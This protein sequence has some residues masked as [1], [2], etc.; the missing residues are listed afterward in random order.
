M[1]V[2]FLDIDG[3]LAWGTWFDGKVKIETDFTIPYPWVQGECDSLSRIIKATDAKIVLSSDWR[4][5]YSIEQMRDIFTH[6][7]IPN[8][9]IDYTSRYKVK[10]SSSGRMDRAKQILNWVKENKPEAW[11]AIDDYNL[12]YEFFMEGYNDNYIATRGDHSEGIS[13][14]ISSQEYDI[15]NILNKKEDDAIF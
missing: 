9:I 12:E 13:S 10:M 5:Y 14:T 8:V 3:P 1:K 15:I 4:L 7:G 6:Y 2:I 11:V